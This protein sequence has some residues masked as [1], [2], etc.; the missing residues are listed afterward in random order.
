MR[1]SNPAGHSVVAV[2]G[3]CQRCC[4]TIWRL[5]RPALSPL[6]DK[7]STANGLCE[8]DKISCL[9]MRECGDSTADSGRFGNGWRFLC[10]P[11]GAPV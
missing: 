9:P 6:L 4:G 1:Q 3:L 2:T 5:R 7:F 11:L 8:N 10:L